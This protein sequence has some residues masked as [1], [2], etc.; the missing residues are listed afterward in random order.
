MWSNYGYHIVRSPVITFFLFTAAATAYGSSQ[1]SNQIG[2]A[3]EATATAA[4]MLDLSHI[5]GLCRSLWQH[6][7]FKSLSEATSSWTLFWVYNLLCHNRN[8]P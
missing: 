6:R 2:A 3:G 8:S 7:I 4:T 1:A 5:C